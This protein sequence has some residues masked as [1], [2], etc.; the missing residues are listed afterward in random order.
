MRKYIIIGAILLLITIPVVAAFFLRKQIITPDP[1][2]LNYWIIEGSKKDYEEIISVYR[3]TQ[4]YVTVNFRE[5]KLEEYDN[6]LIQ[7]WA[8]D[9][10]PDIFE[11]PSTWIRKYQEFIAPMPASVTTYYHETK[12]AFLQET[13]QIRPITTNLPGPEEVKSRYIDIV[14]NNIVLKDS[15]GRS[16]VW[17][18]PYSI[19][20]LALF[21]NK[22][23]LNNAFIVE[24]AQ[25]WNDLV[26]QSS[27]LTLLDNQNNILQS[28]IAL[29]LSSNIKH[30][31]EILSL[32]MLQNGATM[33][34]ADGKKITFNASTET[35][36]FGGRALEFYST[37]ADFDKETYSWNPAQPESRDSF[38]GG[39]SAY[40]LGTLADKK[41]ID[42][43]PGLNYNLAPM[44]HINSDGTDR[45]LNVAG[46]PI[47]INFGQF[48]IHT[49]AKKSAAPQEAWDLVQYIAQEKMNRR[50]VGQTGRI[51]PL[52]NV[53]KSQ[54]TSPELEIWA[55]QALTAKNWYTGR[56]EEAV[57][58]YFAEMIDAVA[59][60][61]QSVSQVLKISAE[62]IEATL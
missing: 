25:T 2:T 44:L 39:K 50:Y 37:F 17:G 12:K 19:D 43:A 42:K 20:T 51:S 48:T 31:Y 35:E 11:L 61:N 49:V 38:S 5:L 22:D 23:I 18:L 54:A 21:Y 41:E 56:D 28:A 10:G 36:S 16:Q 9:Q 30:Y 14:Y 24:P 55:N 52:R 46:N 15:A 57:K 8:R 4:P 58:K 3:A 7:A 26:R 13:V 1:V 34:S 59:L 62:K 29:G 32:L 6:R 27:K 53:L 45:V 47:Q 40:Y 33:I 60:E